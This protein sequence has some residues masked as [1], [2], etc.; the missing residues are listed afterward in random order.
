MDHKPHSGFTAT[1]PSAEPLTGLG[2]SSP[3]PWWGTMS[4][5]IIGNW[6]SSS[7]KRSTFAAKGKHLARVGQLVLCLDFIEGE[8][9]P[10]P[11]HGWEEAADGRTEAGNRA[12][13]PL[14]KPGG[15]GS[16]E[17]AAHLRLPEPRFS[18]ED[19]PNWGVTVEST[20]TERAGGLSARAQAERADLRGYRQPHDYRR[21]GHYAP[22]Q[23]AEGAQ[24]HPPEARLSGSS[25]GSGPVISEAVLALLR[26]MDPAILSLPRELL[27]HLERGELEELIRFAGTGPQAQRGT[28][29]I[30]IGSRVEDSTVQ[31]EKS[32]YWLTSF[33]RHRF[34]IRIGLNNLACA[35]I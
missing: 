23:A 30:G 20:S 25:R 28:A 21:A 27:G 7:S 31:A 13:T 34:L 16:A 10:A 35:A 6:K 3:R 19:A 2:P 22:A 33:L 24:A 1:P 8:I 5:L 4:K 32:G 26:E 29:E 17:S 15:R 12:G 11:G 9:N 18:R 14:C